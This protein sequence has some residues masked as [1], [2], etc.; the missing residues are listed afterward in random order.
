MFQPLCFT[1]F[2]GRG[3][4]GSYKGV[5]LDAGVLQHLDALLEGDAQRL[6]QVLQ[7]LEGVLLADRLQVIRCSTQMKKKAQDT[8]QTAFG[9]DKLLFEGASDYV[10]G[11][12]KDT[13]YLDLC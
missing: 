8:A 11:Y 7:G 1:P 2:G 9:P 3:V 5:C 13:T 10:F 12:C 4:G 6:G